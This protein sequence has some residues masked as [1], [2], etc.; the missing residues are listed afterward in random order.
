MSIWNIIGMIPK[1]G[2]FANSVVNRVHTAVK[3]W[4]KFKKAV[5]QIDDLLKKKKLQLDG[6][7]KTIFE[8]N[9]NILKNHEKVS[10]PSIQ[11]RMDK[12]MATSKRL[13]ELE[14]ERL[15]IYGKKPK[16]PKDPFKGWKPTV[17]EP[18]KNWKPGMYENQQ[19]LP[20]Y[21]K[22]MEKIDNLLNEINAMR[23]LS[24]AEKAAL[25]K[26]LQD[27][28]SSLIDTGRK[29][30][31]YSKLS[32]GEIQKRLH[33]IQTRI[34]EVADNPNIPG[35]VYKGPKKDLIAA[36]YET[37]RPSLWAARNKLIKANNLKKY[38]NKFPM[39]DPDNPNFIV[40]YLDES[41]APVKV[42]RFS[43]KF[44]ATQDKQTGEL[45]R[46]EGMSFWDKWDPKKNK[47]REDGKEVWHETVD[48]E[49]KT[50]MS[51]PDY[52][53]GDLKKLD[54]WDELYSTKST[55]D[56]AKEG[57]TLKDIDM[58]VKGRVARKYLEK[59]KNPDPNI[60]MHEQTHTSD[61]E[62]VMQDLY[63][64]GDDVYKMTIEQWTETLPKFFAQGGPVPGYATGG[65]SNLFRE[66]FSKGTKDPFEE[67]LI[68]EL[69]K[70]L[71]QQAEEGYT[72]ML[73]DWDIQGE[74]KHADGGIAKLFRKRK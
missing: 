35:D 47:M 42:S 38:G 44:S 26:N 45:T 72:E 66:K 39:L 50:M 5:N 53:L 24:K 20:P 14:A 22:E 11:E 21:T 56:L 54:I 37:E 60:N 61:I 7:Q 1:G 2:K 12:I 64:R 58:V 68:A 28:M 46:K 33:G 15:A 74:T 43:G 8:S 49:G 4:D 59:T 48:R 52:K 3:D 65:V 6:K 9:K 34:R 32:L 67:K 16:D 70:Y 69:L 29:N 40:L 73:E 27:K 51:N 62:R 13:D 57:Y 25:E 19:N 10:S 18:V 17:H 55:S 36:I 23:G 63:T 41:G 71:N 31:D 30:F